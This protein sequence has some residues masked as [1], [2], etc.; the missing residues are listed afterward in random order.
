MN[1]ISICTK[2]AKQELDYSIES[3]ETTANIPREGGIMIPK[4]IEESPVGP[5]QWDISRLKQR[6]PSTPLH[7]FRSSAEPTFVDKLNNNNKR[8]ERNN[9]EP[10]RPMPWSS[11]ALRSSPTD[12][13]IAAILDGDVQGIRAVVRS[14]GDD[15]GSAFW[16]VNFHQY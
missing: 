14:K 13:L 16:K 2:A 8:S 12:Q 9:K 7:L 4:S 15:L 6:T 5:V 10:L 11:P 1:F 3:N